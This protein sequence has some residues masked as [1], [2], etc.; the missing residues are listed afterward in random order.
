MQNYKRYRLWIALAVLVLPVLLR[1]AWF[2]HGLPNLARIKTPDYAAA[3][4]PVP[5]VSTTAPET[6]KQV[7]GKVVLVDFVHANQ[8]MPSEVENFF[9]ELTRRGALVEIDNG[10]PSLA[11]RLKFVSTY[12]VFSPASSFSTE[13]IKLVQDFV[14]RGGR[15][16]VFTD[17][18]RGQTTVDY[19]TGATISLPDVDY[20]NPL[21][22]PF[23]IAINKDYLYNLVNNEGN[24]R[25]IFFGKFGKDPLTAGLTRVAFYGV[26][27][28][29]TLNGT[30]LVVGD[31][32]TLSSSTDAGGSLGGA[33]L[34]QN[35]NVLAFGD[36]SFLLPPY[37]TVSDNNLLI[38]HI[39]D[40]ALGG[41][42][43]PG[44][45][46]F[47]YVFERPVS[48][49]PTGG[50]QMAADILSPMASLQNAL[51]TTAITLTVNP[52]PAA[53]SDRLVLGSFSASDGLTPY[54]SSFKLGLDDSGT[55]TLP[56]FGTISREGI[57]LLLYQ[58]TAT[59]NTLVLL[60][61]LPSDLPSLIDL[62]ASG[63][64]S[65]CFI[66]GEVGVCSIGFGNSSYNTPT[67]EFPPV[68][69]PFMEFTP[70]PVK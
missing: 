42:R 21:L 52:E 15:L 31:A 10:D 18:T 13:E 32:S 3:T 34:S 53:N 68:G 24:F 49:V 48:V 69:T 51:Q 36:F 2:Y 62:L 50:L 29:Q 47:P 14:S 37:N 65:S 27:S 45:A 6:I 17:P 61:D 12:I 11:N 67:P 44:V 28:V 22:Q 46:D 25:N 64:L 33:A 59:R 39:A 54:I 16:I 57:G 38:G 8:F 55:I 19:S 70:T 35:G 66:Q 30:S 7:A 58:H 56:D 23:G 41:T 20:V 4:I 9:S 60:T 1:A 43:T 40:F 5:P 63:D 26:H